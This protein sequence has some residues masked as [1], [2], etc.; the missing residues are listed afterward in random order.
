MAVGG[1]WSTSFTLS[2]TSATTLSGNL[3]L[4][5]YQ[6]N[7]LTV[8]SSSMGIGSSFPISVPSGGAVFLTVN[9]LS[10]NDPQKS[11]WVKVETWGGTLNGV[12]TFFQSVSQGAIQNAAGVLSSQPTQFATIPVDENASSSRSTAYAIAN[13]T[14]QILAI[15][16]GLLDSNGILV[17]D[18][19]SIMLNPGQKIARYLNQDFLNRPTFQGSLVFRA[20]EGG[21]FV[22][23]ALIQNQQ[24]YTAVP[25]VP[26][27]SPNIP[28]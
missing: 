18:T 25:V 8:N 10:P 22:A 24:L 27:K 21:T 1:G 3:N 19:V 4:A 7:P 16:L 12:A 17:D 15:R 9:S 23:V 11:G 20:Q 13:P 26:N 14:D 28:D 2:N 5:D 6:G